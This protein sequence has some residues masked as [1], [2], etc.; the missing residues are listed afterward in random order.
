MY[1]SLLASVF[2][3]MGRYLL[4][5]GDKVLVSLW[6]V[7]HQRHRSHLQGTGVYFFGCLLAK[8]LQTPFFDDELDKLTLMAGKL[9]PCLSGCLD[10]LLAR[11]LKIMSRIIH[12]TLLL[13]IAGEV[14]S[15]T[16]MGI[17]FNPPVV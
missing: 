6:L 8:C 1:L 14:R 15:P 10:Y 5:Q 4:D 2:A 7:N 9:A 17:T 11:K 16:T 12:L 3:Q 13:C